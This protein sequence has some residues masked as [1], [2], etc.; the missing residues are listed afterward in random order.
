MAVEAQIG[1]SREL[2][3]TSPLKQLHQSQC[4]RIVGLLS[5]SLSLSLVLGWRI[6]GCAKRC[7]VVKRK[8]DRQIQEVTV[9]NSLP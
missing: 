2:L 7:A 6:L 4:Q 5:L 8:H 9:Y 1:K 3:N